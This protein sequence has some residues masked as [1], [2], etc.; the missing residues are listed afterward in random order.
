LVNDRRELLPQFH[1]ESIPHMTIAG[2]IDLGADWA[3][4]TETWYEKRQHPGFKLQIG[5]SSIEGLEELIE[6]YDGHLD[7]IH[8]MAFP[9]NEIPAEAERT[10]TPC[11]SRPSL[12]FSVST[13]D[14][15]ASSDESNHQILIP[16]RKLFGFL[17]SERKVVGRGAESPVTPCGPSPLQETATSRLSSHEDVEPDADID[18]RVDDRGGVITP[19]PQELNE[20]DVEVTVLSDCLDG[21]DSASP[22]SGSGSRSANTDVSVDSHEPPRKVNPTVN[23]DITPRRRESVASSQATPR[24]F[25]RPPDTPI[26]I[27]R[28]GSISQSQSP[29]LPLPPL[30]TAIETITVPAPTTEQTKMTLKGIRRKRRP[31]LP[32]LFLGLG[33]SSEAPP[34]LPPMPL[35]HH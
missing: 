23:L 6:K 8:N 28:R 24:A 13:T 16:V 2:A 35:D 33:R 12:N 26:A 5:T 20:A 1:A 21:V 3:I 4:C 27:M 30:P 9:P 10:I 15:N 32:H 29:V 18:I 7:T 22:G 19:E 31:T 14:T 17:P 25:P 11:P 34:P